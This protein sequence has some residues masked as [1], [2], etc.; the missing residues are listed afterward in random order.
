MKKTQVTL[1]QVMTLAST[2]V[3]LGAGLGLLLS[4]TLDSRQ[5]KVLGWSLFMLGTITTVPLARSIFNSRR[6]QEDHSAGS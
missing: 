2:R 3:A 4:D 6:A 5:R 1:P